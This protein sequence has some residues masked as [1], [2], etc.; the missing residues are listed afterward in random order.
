MLER[1]GGPTTRGRGRRKVPP[2]G[3]EGGSET[4]PGSGEWRASLGWEDVPQPLDLGTYKSA[5]EAARARN[6]AVI[7]LE[8]TGSLSF[9]GYACG[10]CELLR[11]M[12]I[13]ELLGHLGAVGFR[14][15]WS[16]ADHKA[17]VTG[18][19]CGKPCKQI[20]ERL[21]RAPD[22]V[23]RHLLVWRNVDPGLGHAR[24]ARALSIASN[25]LGIEQECT[26]LLLK[27]GTDKVLAELTRMCSILS[28]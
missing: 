10:L 28:E 23:R 15:R 1:N 24:D 2:R 21:N 16:E 22:E 6:L 11:G 9:D 4:C 27:A 13:E 12:S 25:L 3:Y 18:F 14:K 17:A 19:A 5:S 26:E 20:A 7:C 8:W